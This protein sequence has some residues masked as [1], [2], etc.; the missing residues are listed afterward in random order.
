M[1]TLLSYCGLVDAKIR[2]SVSKISMERPQFL[3]LL[4]SFC[5]ELELQVALTDIKRLYFIKEG[6]HKFF[7]TEIITLKTT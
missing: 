2:A 5:Q 3:H 6:C 1:K 4:W 7:D